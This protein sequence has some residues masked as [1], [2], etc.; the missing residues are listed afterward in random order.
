M[1]WEDA[2][3]CAGQLQVLITPAP[4][5]AVHTAI[6]TALARDEPLAVRVAL[7]PP[8]TWSTAATTDHLDV[9]G[10]FIEQLPQRRRLIL[11]GATDL[12]ATLAGLAEQLHRRVIIVD[13]RAGHLGSGA[14]PA[15]AET[16]LAWP[17]Q[18]MAEHRL[19]ASDAVVVLSHDPRIDDRGIRAALAG[20]AGHV[21]ALGS[22]A[23]LR[24]RLRRLDG[25]PGLKRL[26][27]PAGLDLGGTS[28]AETALSILA[29]IVAAGNG[30]TGGLLRDI[31]LPIHAVPGPAWDLAGSKPGCRA[32]PVHLSAETSPRDTGAV[33]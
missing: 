24:Q 11:V 12:A 25:L 1:P 6:T 30:R 23:T 9:T 20:G 21:A 7:H 4:P 13:P 2:P 19:R 22:R 14:F 16:V 17:D 32:L 33:C 27:A 26:A 29:G 10:A 28:T 3:A 5:A 18:W 8:Y 15:D 31:G